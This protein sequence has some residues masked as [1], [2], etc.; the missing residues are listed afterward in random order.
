M[1][2]APPSAQSTNGM[3]DNQ[4]W[5]IAAVR[6]NRQIWGDGFEFSL[7]RTREVTSPLAW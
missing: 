3:W 2:L 4:H 5:Q 7:R 1:K 6:D